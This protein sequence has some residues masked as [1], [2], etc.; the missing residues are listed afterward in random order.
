MFDSCLCEGRKF[1]NGKALNLKALLHLFSFSGKNTFQRFCRLVPVLKG[2]GGA[3]RL[4]CL[5]LY[6]TRIQKRWV[7]SSS[8]LGV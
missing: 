1:L 4:L 2:V 7:C 5:M 6:R 3:I 8:R